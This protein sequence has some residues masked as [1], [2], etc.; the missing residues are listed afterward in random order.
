MVKPADEYEHRVIAGALARQAS[1][2]NEI[3]ARWLPPDKME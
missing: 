2:S 3:A 1:S